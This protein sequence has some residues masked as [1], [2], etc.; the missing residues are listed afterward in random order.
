M[1]KT[2]K[3]ESLKKRM[4]GVKNKISELNFVLQ[5]LNSEYNKIAHKDYKNIGKNYIGKCYHL[6]SEDIHIKIVSVERTDMEANSIA[7]G[8]TFNTLELVSNRNTYIWVNTRKLESLITED[9]TEE[10]EEKFSEIY[11]TIMGKLN[12]MKNIKHRRKEYNNEE[13]DCD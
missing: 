9:T 6:T 4:N 8:L 10:S 13:S 2:Q 12:K 7:Q 3:V 11:K 1:V 5:R